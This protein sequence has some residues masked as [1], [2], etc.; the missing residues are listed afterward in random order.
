MSKSITTP[1]K[2]VYPRSDTTGLYTPPK[3]VVLSQE[4][5]SHDILRVD[6][7]EQ[8][9]Y[10]EDTLRPGSPVRMFVRTPR[11]PMRWHG[12]VVSVSPLG[13][14]NEEVPRVGCQVLCVGLTF[15]MKENSM[16]TYD[17]LEVDIV[18][19][20]LISSSGLVPF[21]TGTRT[22]LVQTVLSR[23][24]S[25]WTTL[26]RLAHLCGCLVFNT[27]TTVNVLTLRDIFRYYATQG[28][29]LRHVS[30]APDNDPYAFTEFTQ[31]LELPYLNE[32]DSG[33]GRVIAYGVDPV[34]GTPLEYMAGE[35]DP[36]YLNETYLPVVGRSTNSLTSKS[37]AHRL[38]R[39]DEGI[40]VE[41]VGI[42][43]VFAGQPIWFDL[44]DSSHWWLAYGVT[45]TWRDNQHTM[46]IQGVFRDTMV[47]PPP[48]RHPEVTK[49]PLI[50]G[51]HL[52]KE[53]LPV[54]SGGKRRI[55]QGTGGWATKD[56]WVVNRS[57]D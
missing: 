10:V 37:E 19:N 45:H 38:L 23:G 2:V 13:S 29:R 32:S 24:D 55:V 6:Y 18:I 9:A 27:G 14:L 21:M 53:K 52:T 51:V 8:F 40:E 17:G 42:N 46:R 31:D 7:E 5:G 49:R 3:R 1:L 15:P 39:W 30:Q 44:P 11:G 48:L 57:H 25:K 28:I 41:S 35:R 50:D 43:T 56:R 36:M 12:Y 47:A 33:R 22:P 20:D 26:N 54:L 34:S 4:I 16:D